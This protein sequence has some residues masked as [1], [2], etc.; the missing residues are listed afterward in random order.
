MAS[1]GVNADNN[2]ARDIAAQDTRRMKKK[3]KKVVAKKV[4]NSFSFDKAKAEVVAKKNHEEKRRSV[5]EMVEENLAILPAQEVVECRIS[6][7]FGIMAVDRR[8]DVTWDERDLVLDKIQK[9]WPSFVKWAISASVGNIEMQE[10]NLFGG[11]AG[12]ANVYMRR[13]A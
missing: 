7:V 4:I 6:H 3:E 10:R 2:I 12:V 8:G 1:K 11:T 9:E 13:L 5:R